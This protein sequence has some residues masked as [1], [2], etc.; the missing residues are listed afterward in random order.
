MEW[1]E[2]RDEMEKVLMGIITGMLEK[3]Q[4]HFVML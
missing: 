1:L 3:K 2:Q 4:V